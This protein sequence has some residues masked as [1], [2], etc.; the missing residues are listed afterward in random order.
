LPEIIQSL[1]IGARLSRMEQMCIHSF[2]KNGHEVH[3]YLYQDT[4]GVPAGTVVRDGRDVLPASRIFMYRDYATYAG[5]A[6]FFRY[7][8]LLEK[9][10]WFVDADTLCLRPFDFPQ[11]NVFSSQFTND[12]QVVN[13]AALKVPAQSDVM[14]YAWEACERIDPQTLQWEQ[15]GPK[16]I[17]RAVEHFS[18]QRFVRT[19]E[20]FCPLD[21][22]KW[23]DVLDPAINLRY[24]R[25]THGF[26]FWNELWRR[27]GTD[28]DQP[29]NPKCS[30]E[31]WSRDF[32]SSKRRG[33]V[34]QLRTFFGGVT[35][36]GPDQHT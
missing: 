8:L 7:K 16:L 23:R 9:G 2:L 32:Q 5:F 1:W 29:W 4:E 10:G 12:R 18:L 22:S 11:S 13:L 24:G 14:Q 34:D 3:L 17:T 20:V 19:P 26:H 33:L 30:Y 25:Q 15:A 6:N 35:L 27:S 31:R 21:F 28:K 36:K